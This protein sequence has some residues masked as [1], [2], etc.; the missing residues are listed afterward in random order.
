MP[1]A[2]RLGLPL[3]TI[4]LDAVAANWRLLRDLS[5]PA[6]CAGVLKADAYGLGAE[7]VARRLA[8]EGCRTVFVA[9]AEEALSLRAILPDA[10]I[11]VLDGLPSGTA[12]LF[13]RQR[14]RPVLGNVD[15]FS[16]WRAFCEAHGRTPAALHVDTGMNRLGLRVEEAMALTEPD[17][18]S[19]GIELVLSHF[20]AA[21]TPGAIITGRQVDAFAAVRARFPAIRASLA[22]SA[23]IFLDR[24][25]RC[26]LVRPGYALYGGNPTPGKPNPMRGTLRL[27]AP[28]LQVRTVPDG[29]GVGYHGRWLAFGARTIATIGIGYADGFLR[30]GSGEDGRPGGSA[31]VGG[32]AV[33]FAGRVSM[34]LVTLDVTGVPGVKRGDRAQLIGPELPIDAVGASL[35]TSGYEVL[36]GLSR[37]C[38]R[39]YL[40]AVGQQP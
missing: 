37:R 4:D 1:V 5:A 8:A 28:I 21:E 6:E 27:D 10:V 18:L 20:V 40:G 30:S 36:T 34:D 25:V 29:E 16:E 22:N 35:G 7:P 3:L 14:L 12:C 13:A 26:D 2:D 33:P 19:A 24:P 39:R 23:G 11:Y 38:A 9:L 32:A 15:E 17:L 31:I